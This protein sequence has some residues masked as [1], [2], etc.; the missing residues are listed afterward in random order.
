MTVPK[1]Q[2]DAF[3]QWWEITKQRKTPDTQKQ[4]DKLLAYKSLPNNFVLGND[5]CYSYGRH[6]PLLHIT[7]DKKG[8]ITQV[9]LNG[10]RWSGNS[11]FGTP[12]LSHQSWVRG[13][14]QKAGFSHCIIPFSVLEAARLDYNSVVPV[15]VTRDRNE[16]IPHTWTSTGPHD[17]PAGI[18]RITQRNY[19]MQRK[20]QEVIDNLVTSRQEGE[21]AYWETRRQYSEKA[22]QLTEFL[23]SYPVPTVTE[24][25]LANYQL[26]EYV[27][28]ASTV[29]YRPTRWGSEA[30]VETLPDGRRTFRWIENRHWLGE[31]V[32]KA[33][34]FLEHTSHVQR[35]CS[36]TPT[37]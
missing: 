28:I 8:N 36:L 9:I 7:R 30:E 14:V 34:A 1:T 16:E 3:A 13:A 35:L 20:S 17:L 19:E 31:C 15:E 4:L 33:R 10:D 37:L 25:S 24:E 22:G 5:V 32:I 6:F 12:T 23:T 29:H 26:N 18:K 11:G 21:N 2:F 27:E